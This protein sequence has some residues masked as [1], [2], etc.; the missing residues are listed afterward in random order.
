[1]EIRCLGAKKALETTKACFLLI[2]SE[3]FGHLGISSRTYI[4]Y[5]TKD[6]KGRM[7]K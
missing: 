4:V 2:V 6:I 3:S 7:C 5:Y 1:M